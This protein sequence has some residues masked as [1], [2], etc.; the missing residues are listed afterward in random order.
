MEHALEI[1]S[2]ARALVV[3]K[4]R[5]LDMFLSDFSF[6]GFSIGVSLLTLLLWHFL[7]ISET[8]TLLQKFYL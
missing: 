6:R 7:S 5:R 3:R 2:G 1:A 8:K 4:C